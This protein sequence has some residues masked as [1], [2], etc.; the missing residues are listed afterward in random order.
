MYF[1]L[2]CVQ[3][4]WMVSIRIM[5]DSKKFEYKDSFKWFQDIKYSRTLTTP[6]KLLFST[7]VATLHVLVLPT[8]V[9]WYSLFR[10]IPSV[11]YKE[12]D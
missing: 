1:L 6:G 8:T 12:V 2:F 9:L 10:V 7:L 5:Y 3:V 4:V 11:L